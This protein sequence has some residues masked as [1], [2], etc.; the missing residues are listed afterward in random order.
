MEKVIVVGNNHHNTL[1]IVRSLG[2]AG[3][4]VSC[5]VVDAAIRNSF[6]GK[7]KYIHDFKLFKSF[8][9]LL[10]F[11]KREI[12]DERIPVFTTSD[13]ASDFIDTHYAELS[14]N[15]LL[16][17]CGHR[18]GGISYWMN[19]EIMLSKAKECGLVVPN[20]V[21]FNTSFDLG[22][23][24]EDI[25]F[26]CIVKPQKSSLAGKNNFRI[27]NN[28]EQ[29]E[30]A[31]VEVSEHC[32]E[33]LIQEYIKR[34]YEVLVMGM[35]STNINKTVIPG[36]LHKLRVCQHT[37]SLGMLAYAYTSG[38]VDP[39]IDVEAMRQF[40]DAIDYDGIF[41]MEFMIANGKA[42]FLEI[43]LRNDG[44]QFCF[45]GAGVNLP[46]LWIKA[47]LGEDIKSYKTCLDKKYCVVE[48]NYF[49]NVDWHH[50][51]TVIKELRSTNLFALFDKKDW[52]PA[53]YK[54]KYSLVKRFPIK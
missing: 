42:Y 36:C 27:C 23:I 5:Y 19:K 52:K 25:V 8:D 17:S 11:M 39:A 35:R 24:P 28:R 45:E 14:Q 26:P 40:L 13:A 43:N 29:L 20:G 30:G 6:V 22:A 46:M 12:I 10:E 31:I 44:T 21:H 37:K 41:S 38:M 47:S 48:A 1:G 53:F 3:M 2:R 34:D 49:R 50:P 15:Y 7:S 51:L 4:S 33:V 16:N 32:T 9:Y 54:L 18:Q